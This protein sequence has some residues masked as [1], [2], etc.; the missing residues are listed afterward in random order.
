MLAHDEPIYDRI[1]T[2][3]SREQ[4]RQQLAAQVADFERNGGQVQRLDG[5]QAATP[6]PP[7]SWN[8]SI[9]RQRK[10][11]RQHELLQQVLAEQI[12]EVAITETKIGPFVHTASEVRRKLKARGIKVNTLQ[13]EQIAA[14]YLIELRDDGRGRV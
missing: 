12:R 10:I 7:T 2:L 11:R 14:K 6:P 9:T 13:I 3:A 1:N 8:S 5:F 4:A